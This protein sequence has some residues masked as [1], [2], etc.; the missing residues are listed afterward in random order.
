[1]VGKDAHPLVKNSVTFLNNVLEAV[2]FLRS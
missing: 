1:M 2:Y